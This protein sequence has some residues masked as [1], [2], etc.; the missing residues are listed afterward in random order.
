MRLFVFRNKESDCI[1]MEYGESPDCF[2]DDGDL[3]YLSDFRAPNDMFY[4]MLEET[5]R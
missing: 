5:K 2:P 4:A 3:Y 1:G